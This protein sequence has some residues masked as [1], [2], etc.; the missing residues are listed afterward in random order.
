MTMKAT[1]ERKRRRAYRR[2]KDAQR[3]A[4]RSGPV[5]EG[6]RAPDG[7]VVYTAAH[8]TTCPACQLPITAGA[9][10]VNT[11]GAWLHLGCR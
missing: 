6:R 7:T 11:A 9:D 3:W 8:E 5:I 4:A 2:K 10:M 1:P